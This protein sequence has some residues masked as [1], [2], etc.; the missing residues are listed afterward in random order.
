[1]KKT[2]IAP[3]TEINQALQLQLLVG[4]GVKGQMDDNLDIGFGGTDEKGG[5]DPSA[6]YGNWDNDSWD[7]L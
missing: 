2:Y 5:K 4:S 1:M 6:N 3:M 7:K